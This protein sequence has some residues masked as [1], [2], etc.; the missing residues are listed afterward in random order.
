MGENEYWAGLFQPI[1]GTSNS[2]VNFILRNVHINLEDSE[3]DPFLFGDSNDL[4]TGNAG[5]H[6]GFIRSHRYIDDSG[7]KAYYEYCNI[8][9]YMCQ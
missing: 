4:T 7:D 1:S 6:G 8:Q 9:N 3:M 2:V 5:G